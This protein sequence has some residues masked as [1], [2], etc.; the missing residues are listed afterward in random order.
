MSPAG[1]AHRVVDS[2]AFRPALTIYVASVLAAAAATA[3][4]VRVDVSLVLGGVVTV[5]AVTASMHREIRLVHTLVNSQHDELV[6]RV[7]Q[8]TDTLHAAGVGV[9]NKAG[10]GE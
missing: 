5:L 3:G 2:I 8:L 6:A 10:G 4:W 1:Y 9:P 7:A